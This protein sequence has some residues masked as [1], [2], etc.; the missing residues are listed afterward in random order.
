M[1]YTSKLLI[2]VL[3]VIP[4]ACANQQETAHKPLPT[5]EKPP[6]TKENT[7]PVPSILDEENALSSEAFRKIVAD[8]GGKVSFVFEDDRPFA[9]CHASTL[10]QAPDGTV[11]AAWFAGTKEKDSDVGIWISRCV[12]DKWTPPAL[13]A[14]VEES[15]HWNPVLFTD[16]EDVV[17]L[18][19]KVGPEISHWRTYWMHSQDNGASWT[20]P[21]ELVPGDAGGRGPVKNKPIILSDGSW[22]APASTELGPWEPFSDRSTDRGKTW[23]RSD[24]FE[25]DRKKLKGKG[26]IQPTLWESTPGKIHA[27]LRTASGNVWRTDSNDYGVTW[28]PV[29]ETGLPNNN[30]GLDVLRL[31]GGQLLLVLNPVGMNWGPRTPLSLALS[32]DNGLSWTIIAHLEDDPIETKHEYSYPAIIRTQTGIAISYTWRRERVRCWL[33]DDKALTD[34]TAPCQ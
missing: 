11:I 12:D 4:V 21:G 10:T 17:Y 5:D 34:I 13:A 31:D 33:I 8:T 14:K 32:C 25:I 27:L 3:V 24:N 29:Y 23:Q 22:L 19:F 16:A 6:V 28:S 2:A 30:S 18:F 1:K 15:A 7:M 26:A 9:Q 20:P